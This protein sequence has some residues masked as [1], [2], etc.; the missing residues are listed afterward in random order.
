MS[1]DVDAPV[2]AEEPPGGD[3]VIDRP[4]A[5]PGGGQLCPRHHAVLG[6]GERG[7]C[8][9]AL[10]L[11]L[12]NRTRAVPWEA[13]GDFCIATMHNCESLLG[14]VPRVLLCMALGAHAPSL[15][16]PTTATEPRNANRY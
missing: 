11:D 5:Q 13:R 16:D 9:I 7:N 12:H 15:P 4:A 8:H 14:T 6:C 3:A 2:H 10:P 1:N